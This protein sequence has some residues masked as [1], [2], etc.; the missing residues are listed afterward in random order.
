MQTTCAARMP[1]SSRRPSSASCRGQ[2][3]AVGMNIRLAE[4]SDLAAL[5]A[6]SRTAGEAAHWSREQWLAIFDSQ[7]PPRLAWIAEGVTESP[8]SAEPVGFLV[9]QC[10]NEDWELENV[11]VLPAFRR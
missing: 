6:M 7:T 4:L 5:E 10:G 1:N 3:E 11:A 8:G 9:A 2:S